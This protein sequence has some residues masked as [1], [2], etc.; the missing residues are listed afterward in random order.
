M[1]YLT[2]N[3]STFL[4]QIS[5][6]FT[7]F[8]QRWWANKSLLTSIILFFCISLTACEDP[9]EIG[10][11]VFVQD[12]GILFTDTLTVDASTVLLDS[13]ATSNTSNLLV[14]RYIDPKLGLVEASSYFHI[15]NADTLYSSVDT[16]GRK[17]V[18]WL[19]YPSKVDS[20]RFIMPY[21]LYQGDT[22]QPQTFNLTQLSDDASLDATLSYYRTSTAPSL[23]STLLGQAKNV[24]IRPVKDKNII[25][26]TSRF[27]TLRIPITDPTFVNFIASQRDLQSSKDNVLIGT[28]FRNKIRGLA[29]TSESAKN[30]AILGISSDLSVLKVYY[31]YKYI[32]T[33]RN[34]ANTAD[35][36]RVTVDTTKSNNLYIGLYT[37]STGAAQN[38]RFVKITPTKTGTFTKLEKGG[39]IVPASSTSNEVVVQAATGL[40][41]KLNF[42]TLAKLKNGRDVAINKAELVLEPNDNTGLSL[43]SDLVIIESTPANRPLR[44][45]TTGE[46]TI[47]FV[48]GE[49]YSAAYVAKSNTYTFNVTS[50]LQNILSGRNKSNGWLLSSTSFVTNSSTGTR[51][52]SSSKNI[53][54]PTPDRAVFNNS[55]MKLKIYY[56]YVAK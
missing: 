37:S 4:K 50:S 17:N 2:K 7:I 56:T 3:L 32:Y 53:V 14:G 55:K 6:V 33:L 54:S 12:I 30:A 23:K 36:I 40:G 48:S 43:P 25:S 49:S 35:S 29:L 45:T 18:T 28:G 10:S 24:R 11:D 42:P 21:T 31:H 8:T 9:Q 34:A 1:N 15:A 52:P 51:S 19:K 5:T 46:G 16:A 27:D 41:V 26:G 44:T 22:L 38:A 47:Y 13:V 20:I 39:D